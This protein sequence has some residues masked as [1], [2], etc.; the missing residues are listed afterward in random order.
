MIIIMDTS[1]AENSAIQKLYII[2]IIKSYH[3]IPSQI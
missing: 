3:I 2:I 1:M